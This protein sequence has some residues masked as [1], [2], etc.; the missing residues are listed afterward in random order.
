MPIKVMVL[1][2]IVAVAG[3]LGVNSVFIVSELERAVPA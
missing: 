3:L 2:F 1:A